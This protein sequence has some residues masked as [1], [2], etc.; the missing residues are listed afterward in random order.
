[1]QNI[2]NKATA[3][4]LLILDVDGVMTDG[5]IYFTSTG[6]EM[7]SFHTLDG[8][9]LKMLQKSGVKL[10]IITGRDAPCVAHRAK[11][12]NI[13]YYYAGI[14]DKLTCFQK[15]LQESGFSPE[16]CAY[17]GDDV[18]DLSVMLRVGLSIAPPQAHSYVLKRASF[19]TK[20][21]AGVGAVREACEFILSAQNN[22]ETA[23]AEYLV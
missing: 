5:R 2:L 12:L 21:S 23:M 17:M 3:V 1:M 22:L 18:V 10:A 19:I 16:Q 13:D 15:L 20:A 4:K 7:K 11:N 6:E 14:A 8:H 9:G